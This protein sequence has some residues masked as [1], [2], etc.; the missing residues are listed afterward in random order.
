[1][2]LSEDRNGPL[3]RTSAPF[4]PVFTTF[5]KFAFHPWAPIRTQVANQ[6]TLRGRRA[7]SPTG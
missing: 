2:I 1:M 7:S 5:E 3:R 4:S 6:R